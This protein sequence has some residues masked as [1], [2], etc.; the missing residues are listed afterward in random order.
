MLTLQNINVQFGDKSV[1]KNLSCTIENGDFIVILGVNGAGK[2]TFFDII[3]GKIQPVSGSIVLDGID[4]VGLSE[5]S[6]AHMVTRIFQ[7]TRLNCVGSMTVAQNLAIAR[8]SRR[9]IRLCNGMNDLSDNI[10]A[11][12]IQDLGMDISILDVPMSKLSGGQRQ[13]IAFVMAMQHI[14]QILLL[15][16]PTAALDPQASTK[17]LVYAKNF[18]AQHRVTTLLITHD[19]HIA[20]NLGN[21]VWVLEDGKI[22]KMFN[23]QDKKNLNPNDLIGHIDYVELAR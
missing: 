10:A 11:K 20:L 8:Y 23:Q 6:R 3:S 2:S 9:S 1:L 14:P 18:I 12:I 19:P 7:N 15:D 16:E 4:I 17:L 13:L 21:K 22:S 5:L